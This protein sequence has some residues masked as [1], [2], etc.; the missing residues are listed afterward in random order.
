[1]DREKKF[2]L[3]GREGDLAI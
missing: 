2:C 3:Q 1:M